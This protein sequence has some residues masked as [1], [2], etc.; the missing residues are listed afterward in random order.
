M[1]KERTFK[2]RNLSVRLTEEEWKLLHEKWNAST[3]RHFVDYIR[4]LIF[5]T[6]IVTTVRSRSLDEFLPVAGGI[7]EELAGI[8]RDFTRALKHLQERPP[9]AAITEALTSLRT[10]QFSVDHHIDA[11]RQSITKIYDN[12]RLVQ[13]VR[14]N[15]VA[16]RL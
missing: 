16:D 13:D 5:H 8:R 12:V 3:F 1:K 7:H 2:N 11:I 4:A 15:E 9:D 10:A 6:P 14:G